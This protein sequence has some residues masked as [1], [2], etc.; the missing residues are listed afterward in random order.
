VENDTITPVL[1]GLISNNH[2]LFTN[3]PKKFFTGC[4]QYENKALTEMEM[5]MLNDIKTILTNS[6]A[7]LVEDSVGL[8]ALFTMLL[9][10]LHLSGAA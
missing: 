9:V 1:P 5:T 10:G 8:I 4:L 6:R 3:V 2:L 7:T